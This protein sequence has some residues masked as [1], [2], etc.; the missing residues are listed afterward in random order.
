MRVTHPGL[1]A[2]LHDEVPARYM[3]RVGHYALNL[4]HIDRDQNR[5]TY[6]EENLRVQHP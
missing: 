5:G 4:V 2:V 1:S 6:V 3:R